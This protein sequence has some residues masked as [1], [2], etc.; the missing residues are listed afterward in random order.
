MGLFPQK[1]VLV[2]LRSFDLYQKKKQLCRRKFFSSSLFSL[3]KLNLK[4]QQKRSFLF[5]LLYLLIREREKKRDEK[6]RNDRFCCRKIEFSNWVFSK[7]KGL[8]WKIFFY[9]IVSF[10]NTN[11]IST[12]K[13]ALFL[14]KQTHLSNFKEFSTII[15]E[16]GLNLH[17]FDLQSANRGNL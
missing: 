9:K 8:N 4:I 2:F 3:R 5:F 12:E 11:Q 17:I 7:K 10:F 15:N 6:Q 1:K 13:Q 14:R 16:I